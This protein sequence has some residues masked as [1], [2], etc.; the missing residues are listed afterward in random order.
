M[1]DVKRQVSKQ[2][3]ERKAEGQMGKT[4]ENLRLLN[5]KFRGIHRNSSLLMFLYTYTSTYVNINI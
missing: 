5:E 4:R 2:C 1:F 3:E